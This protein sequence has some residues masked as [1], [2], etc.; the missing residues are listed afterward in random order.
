[1]KDDTRKKRITAAVL[2]VLIIAAVAVF[3]VSICMKW[4]LTRLCDISTLPAEI[5]SLNIHESGSITG[6]RD[7]DT[8]IYKEG[9]KYF[10]EYIDHSK[11]ENP[12]RVELTKTEFLLCTYVDENYLEEALPSTSSDNIYYEI[13][14]TRQDGGEVTVPRRSYGLPYFGLIY[15]IR[16]K[17]NYIADEDFDYDRCIKLASYLYAQNVEC[18]MLSGE[19][20]KGIPRN[21]F[22]LKKNYDFI[23]EMRKEIQ[24][25]S[26]KMRNS[27]K[28]EAVAE[29]EELRR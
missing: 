17:D 10:I 23:T 22:M 12:E 5:D 18:S 24:D 20:S 14:I 25:I 3:A 27:K 6:R 21:M 26:L 8:T 2:A 13:T 4:R 28:P 16:E 19:T 29:R 9:S 7:V 15:I 1:M 11:S